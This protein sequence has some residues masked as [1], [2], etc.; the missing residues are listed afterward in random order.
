MGK[1][2]IILATAVF[3]VGI[4]ASCGVSDKMLDDAD[5]RLT[6]LKAKGL[7]DSLLSQ[8]QVHLYQARDAKRR[9]Q[10]SDTKG[11]ERIAAKLLKK[12]LAKAESFYQEKVSKLRP[13]VDS[14]RAVIKKS[15]EHYTGIL[16]KRFDSL[17]AVVD[18]FSTME[19]LLQSYARAKELV[20]LIPQFTA[21]VERATSLRDSI[22][23]E[24]VCTQH[25]KSTEN[26]EVNAI[27]KKTFTF[28][29]NGRAKFVESKKGQSGPYLKEDWEFVSN[30]TWETAGDTIYLFINRFAAVR[31]MFERLYLLDGG[32]KKEWRKEPKPTYDSTITDHTQDR[33]IAFFDLK[34]DFEHTKK[35]K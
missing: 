14:L 31:Q 22:P 29:K 8:P 33:F 6:M 34:E 10:F 25:D 16:L 28:E 13:Q 21:D 7:P 35:Y 26:K 19:W 12:E 17:S 2:V 27:T 9:S 24:W 5:K 18:S 3:I 30:G 32:K 1:R 4:I 11:E 23:G 15:R 20:G